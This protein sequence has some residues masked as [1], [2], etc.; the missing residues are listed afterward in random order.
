HRKCAR[1]P[2]QCRDRSDPDWNT[3]TGSWWWRWRWWRRS[4]W[5]RSTRAERARPLESGPSAGESY[6]P[7]TVRRARR[8]LLDQPGRLRDRRTTVGR[9]HLYHALPSRE[10]GAERG[11]VGAG[12]AHHLLRRS[13][14]SG[15]VEAVGEKGDPGL[16]T[17]IRGGRF[18][19]RD[20][21][22][23]SAGE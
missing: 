1:I 13:R 18:Q 2:G 9:S 5:W 20:P 17:G 3:D 22:P 21:C 23:G 12:Q 15:A 8:I 7:T 10:K 6:G 16:A 14:D 19:K 11:T 4:G